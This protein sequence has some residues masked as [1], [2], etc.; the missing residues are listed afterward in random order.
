MEKQPK[1]QMAQPYNGT[2][3]S[4]KRRRI[5]DTYNMDGMENTD[6]EWEKPD[7]KE[8][9]LYDSIYIKL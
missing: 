8:H 1:C 3:F 9:M 6:A 2:P 5:A 4:N 7:K